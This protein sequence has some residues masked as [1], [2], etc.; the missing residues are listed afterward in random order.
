ML[1][2][3]LLPMLAAF[4]ISVIATRVAVT[5]AGRLAF[6]DRP[7]AEAH[8][9]QARAV[10]YGGGAAMA[11]AFAAA[12]VLALG[13]PP[14]EID[15]V[16]DHG[17][18]W[19]LFTGTAALFL[20]GLIDDLRPLGA[21]TKLLAQVV[22]AGGT[23]WF[24]DLALD[25]LRTYP[26]LAYG[27]AWAWLVL[28]SNA[29]NLLDHDDGLCGSIAVVS[30]LVLFSGAQLSGDT[31]LAQLWLVLVGA[32]L[33][34]LVWN[35]PPARIYMG[36]AGS[37]PLGFLIGAGTL[38]VT[39][40]PSGESGSQL[41]ILAPVL[42]TALPLFDT[43]TVVVKRLRRG[44]PIMQGD[45]N[46][47]SHRLNRLGMT[48]RRRLLIAV[49]VQVALAAGALQLRTQDLL[50]AVVVIAQSAAIFIVVVL[51][52]TTRDHND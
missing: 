8:K 48:P 32:V 27:L 5:L 38:S 24:G 33:G 11:V 47:I 31:A 39:F 37:L 2:S 13:L 12:L 9:Q 51:L 35:R 18:L 29:Y 52:E 7:G 19:P 21:R 36:D 43:A 20:V 23:V 4:V 45:R 28:V 26:V 3:L 17:P 15:G 1:G 34:F 16:P 14:L 50:T 42:I 6:L 22:I 30:A 49:A 41:A 46:H 10:P 25:S 44:T 40:W